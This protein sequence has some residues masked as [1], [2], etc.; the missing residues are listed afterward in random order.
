MLGKLAGVDFSLW[1]IKVEAVCPIIDK[2]FDMLNF[3]CI[4]FNSSSE[5]FP[6]FG[7]DLYVRVNKHGKDHLLGN[8][9]SLSSMIS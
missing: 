1:L 8:L 6:P 9:F 2:V 3:V 4:T 7:C 5:I